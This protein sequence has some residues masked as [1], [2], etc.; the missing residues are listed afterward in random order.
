MRSITFQQYVW[1]AQLRDNTRLPLFKNF[2][3]TMCFWCGVTL[4]YVWSSLRQRINSLK[5]TKAYDSNTQQCMYNRLEHTIFGSR[6]RLGAENF[7]EY[8]QFS[9]LLRIFLLFKKNIFNIYFNLDNVVVKSLVIDLCIS[10]NLFGG[11][12]IY[13]ENQGSPESFLITVKNVL[14]NR[15]YFIILMGIFTAAIIYLVRRNERLIKYS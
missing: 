1:Y 14:N 2:F 9:N 13:L 5:Y 4:R 7:I 15:I 11:P 8:F 10:V 6:E 3:L 12:S